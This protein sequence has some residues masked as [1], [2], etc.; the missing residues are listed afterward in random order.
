MVRGE[1]RSAESEQKRKEIGLD[2][3]LGT[4]RNFPIKHRGLTW[5][6][7][8]GVRRMNACTSDKCH[9]KGGVVTLLFVLNSCLQ[10]LVVLRAMVATSD[11]HRNAEVIHT[12]GTLPV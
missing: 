10:V 2:T 5:F 8:D 6:C 11:L 1:E 9:A 7:V 12:S 3:A 4:E